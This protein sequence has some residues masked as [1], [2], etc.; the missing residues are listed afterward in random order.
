MTVRLQRRQFLIGTAS[1]AASL[2]SAGK[3]TAPSVRPPGRQHV[4]PILLNQNENPYGISQTAVQAI[5]KNLATANRYPENPLRQLRDM[6]AAHEGVA[7]DQVILGA[8]SA[9]ILSLSTLLFGAEGKE[10]VMADPGYFDFKD[11]VL[12]TGGKLHSVPLDAQHRHDLSAM[13]RRCTGKVKLVYVCNPN[14]PTGTIVAAATLRAFYEQVSR[15]AVV[16]VDEAYHEFVEDPAYGSMLDLGRTGQN[17]IV[18]RTF[19]KIHGLAGLRIGYAIAA[20]GIIAELRRVQTNF[21]PISALSLAAAS[22]SYRD[23][24][25][26]DY[27]RRGNSDVKARFCAS[28]DSLHYAYIPSQTNFV[29]FQVGRDSKGF[30]EDMVKSGILV[31]PYA[32]FG[33]Q[34]IRA[35]I[36]TRSEMDHLTSALQ[37]LA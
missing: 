37:E 35:S 10:V 3:E 32:F 8:G 33:K 15:R 36:G 29:I 11:F 5:L 28:L 7:K 12:S 24:E 17:V 27:C 22:A 21:A 25:F 16:L 9:E 1:L 6:I 31:R 20:P 13:E 14:N 30:A 2:G 4:N 19:S 18:T 26:V 34:W 23:T